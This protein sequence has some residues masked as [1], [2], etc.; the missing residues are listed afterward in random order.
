[1]TVAATP[2]ASTTC[3]GASI[4]ATGGAGQFSLADAS[5]APGASC[6]ATVTVSVTGAG[7]FNNR[8]SATLG[9]PGAITN[10]QGVAALADAV[11]TLTTTAAVVPT[12]GSY[13]VA[14]LALLLGTLGIRRMRP[15]SRS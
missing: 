15:S 9:Q 11:A 8:I 6:T 5:L 1:M 4:S 7:T 12:L 3:A 2:G 14:A 10:T 13:A